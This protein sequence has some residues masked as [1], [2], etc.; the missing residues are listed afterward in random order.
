MQ[1]QLFHLKK[2][3]YGF[4]FRAFYCCFVER[5]WFE[6]ASKNLGKWCQKGAPM[7]QLTPKLSY[8]LCF[9]FCT[10]FQEDWLKVCADINSLLF[11]CNKELQKKFAPMLIVCRRLCHSEK[12]KNWH[13]F[14]SRYD[15]DLQSFKNVMFFDGVSVEKIKSQ[16][17]SGVQCCFKS[18]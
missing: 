13:K 11:L 1:G 15:F 5:Y 7:S 4:K 12:N 3:I 6:T 10:S 2:Y 8:T 18:I 14:W 9:S 16:A 17:F